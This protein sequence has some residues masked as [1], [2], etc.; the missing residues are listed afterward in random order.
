MSAA[1]KFWI[2]SIGRKILMAVT[3]VLLLLFI[4]GHMVGNLQIFI[5]AEALNRY[6]AF[7]QGLGE[8]LWVIR[9]GLLVV[10]VVHIILS[11]QLT[12]EN[13]S[14]R[15]IKYRC[16]DTVQASL[17]SRTMIWTGLLVL[18]FII[19][20]ILHFT[21]GVLQPE[22]FHEM[23]TKEPP[24][25]YSIVVMGFQNIGFA[26]FYILLMICLGFH[27][28]HAIMS[29]CETLGLN[30]SKY[31]PTVTKLSVILGWVIAV[32]YIVVPLSVLVGLVN[33][34]AGGM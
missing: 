3:G 23:H 20:H 14:A 12:L 2:S 30:H 19:L 32:G 34:P 27:V 9:F 24:D 15:P 18:G 17:A 7:L 26:S 31:H 11:I 16:E 4:F 13:R 28:S 6:A 33:L 21:M 8:L 10:F 29:A 5:G 25:V 22:I 1:E